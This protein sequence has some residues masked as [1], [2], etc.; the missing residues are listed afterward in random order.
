[1][2]YPNITQYKEAIIE[3]DS[4][5]TL[6]IDNFPVQN[7]KDLVMASGN[8]ACVFKMQHK[9]RF[10]ALKCFT[11]DI[12]ERAERQKKIVEYIKNNPSPYLVDYQYLENEIWI[13]LNGGMELPVTW[14][15]WIEAPTLGQKIKE[16]CEADDKEGLKLLT[17]KFRE[18][19]LWLLEQPFAHGD[20]KHDNLLVK[21]DGSLV[22][23]DYDGMFIPD[24]EDKKALELGSKCYQ[25]PKRNENHFNRDIDD[26]SILIIYTSLLALSEKPELY[27]KF[28]NGQNI[29]FDVSDFEHKTDLVLNLESNTYFKNLIKTFNQSI[30]SDTILLQNL[31]GFL[32]QYEAIEWWLSNNGQLRHKLPV[33]MLFAIKRLYNLR[34]LKQ[35]CQAK[36]FRPILLYRYK[37]CWKKVPLN[38][39]DEITKNNDIKKVAKLKANEIV[40]IFLSVKE[41]KFKGSDVKALKFLSFFSNLEKLIIKDNNCD[42][43]PLTKLN[44]LKS[45]YLENNEASI[46]PLS[47]LTRVKKIGLFGNKK[48]LSPVSCMHSVKSLELYFNLT[49]LEPISNMSKLEKLDIVGDWADIGN[50]KN[51]KNLKE[52]RIRYKNYRV[53]PLTNLD[54]LEKLDLSCSNFDISIVEP[55]KK[56]RKLT[57]NR[58]NGSIVDRNELKA[59][60]SY[61]ND[62]SQ[63]IHKHNDIKIIKRLNIDKVDISPISHLIALEELE[64]NYPIDFSP[65]ESLQNLK[66]LTIN[67]FNGDFRS[68]YKLSRDIEFK[69]GEGAISKKL[70]DILPPPTPVPNKNSKQTVNSG[71]SI[72]PNDVV[73]DKIYRAK[74]G[75]DD[76]YIVLR[77]LDGKDNGNGK[78]KGSNIMISAAKLMHKQAQEDLK[79]ITSEPGEPI[80]F[81]HYLKIGIDNGKYIITY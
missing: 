64:F 50:L 70:D 69:E 33:F 43:T 6:N 8:F 13:D 75:I 26:F 29:I 12:P 54:N 47:S 79:F 57:V 61:F 46:E 21:E 71:F 9:G 80:E 27:A 19:A 4:F 39:K 48:E 32:V 22:M 45:L 56:L 7:G 68:L 58:L 20:L 10:R 41:L 73:V 74:K 62:Y 16:Y 2:Q 36:I 44:N 37:Q 49:D 11:K 3:P 72:A 18:F 60:F 34:V 53:Q 78:P 42:L 14:M 25:H 67:E 81:N 51:L 38:I 31:S 24:F 76:L 5:A 66:L 15:E 35:S 28:N 65:L 63:K 59:I 55:L 1:M 23:V 40:D 30:S 17:E 77:V 52:L